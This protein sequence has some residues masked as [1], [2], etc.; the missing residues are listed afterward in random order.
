M[1]QEGKKNANRWWYGW[2]IGYSAATVVQGTAIFFSEDLS[3][4]Q[5]LA[6]G[7]VTTFLGAAGQVIAPMVPGYASA[8]LEKLPEMTREERLNKLSEAETLLMESSRREA[9][10]RSWKTHVFFSLVNLGS[11]LIT[12]I[13]FDRDIWAG[14]ENFAL[15]TVITE[16]QIFSQPTRAIKDYRYY[17]RKYGA[18]F[19]QGNLKPE[20]YLDVNVYAGGFQIRVVF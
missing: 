18:G 2:L 7:S 16:A 13:G 8:R 11:G 12:W 4:R 1:L 3:T 9:S 15:N 6:L 10:G 19:E 14:L 5:D 17:Q 20:V